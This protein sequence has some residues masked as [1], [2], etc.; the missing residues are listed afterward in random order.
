MTDSTYFVKW[1]PLRAFTGSFQHFADMYS[2][3][4]DVHEEVWCWKNIFL[5][6]L[7]G[8]LTAIFRQLHLVNNGW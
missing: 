7:T 2:H 5:N 3:I 6:K 1:T 4:E 8:F